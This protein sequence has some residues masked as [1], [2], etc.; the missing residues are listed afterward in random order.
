MDAFYAS[1]EERDQ[2]QLVGKPVIVGG[3]PAGRGVVAAANYVIRKYGVHSAMPTST[4]LRLCPHAIVLPVRMNHYA[5]ISRQIQEVFHRFTPLVEPLSLDEAFLDVS[6]SLKLFGSPEVI[7]QRIQKEIRQEVNLAASVGVATNKFL[8]KLASDLEKPNGFVIVDPNGI[9]NF[10][11]DLPV[12]RIWG[13]GKVRGKSFEQIGIKTI[14]QLRLLTREILDA[15]FG[16]QS[17][18]HLW[19]LARGIDNRAVVPDRNAKSISHETTFATDVT[20]KEALRCRLM[21][22]TEQVGRRLRHHKLRCRTVH[23]KIRYDDFSTFTRAQAVAEPTNSTD[24]LWRI[25]VKMLNDR[26]P[27][28]NLS[29]RLLGMGVSGIDDKQLKQKTLF[30]E[31][32][33]HIESK[34]DAVT[35][36]IQEKFGSNSVHRGRSHAKDGR[37]RNE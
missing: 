2:P 19:K 7:G 10:L 13:V 6:G 17:G 29:I 31:E 37:K 33:N 32:T 28:R 18:E 30:E 1:I 35:D 36:L 12:G 14:G 16:A 26:L 34:I 20:D 15:R 27:D 21:E 3:T 24:Q 9:Q 23:L 11:D 25:A 5:A 8:A 4:A 22:L